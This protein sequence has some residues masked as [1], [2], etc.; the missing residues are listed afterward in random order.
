MTCQRSGQSQN[1]RIF[2]LRVPQS[3]NLRLQLHIDRPGGLAKL[4]EQRLSGTFVSGDGPILQVFQFVGRQTSG[5]R[6][7]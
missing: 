1:I 7:R 4:F 2:P 5:N 6:R 3:L